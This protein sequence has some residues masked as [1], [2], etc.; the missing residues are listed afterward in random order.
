MTNTDYLAK[1]LMSGLNNKFYNNTFSFFLPG[2]CEPVIQRFY[3]IH[4]NSCKYVMFMQSTSSKC[5][6]NLQMQVKKSIRNR[7]IIHGLSWFERPVSDLHL[8][9]WNEKKTP[10]ASWDAFYHSETFGFIN[11]GCVLVMFCYVFS[12]FEILFCFL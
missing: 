6:A 11:L 12:Y 8:C 10:G 7:N 2:L 4:N 3:L 5:N 1:A 9:E